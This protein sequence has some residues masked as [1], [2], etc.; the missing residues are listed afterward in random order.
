MNLAILGCG[1]WAQYQIA[2][3]REVGGVTIVGV[4]DRD[5][6]K[7]E[8]TAQR[9]GVPQVFTDA[10]ELL[11]GT[12][13]DCVD[14]ISS[15]E[16]HEAL[17]LL[18]AERGV[19]VICQKPMAPDW[20]ACERMVAACEAAGVPFFIHENF[21][22]QVPIR[23]VKALLDSGEIGRPFRS[24][25]YFNTNFPVFDNQPNL[26]DLE[27]FILADLGVHLLDVQ[28]FLFGEVRSLRCLTQTALPAVRGEDVATILLETVGG[29]HGVVELSF[30]SLVPD[31]A[32]PQTLLRVEGTEG[33]VALG[34]D[35]AL[36]VTTRAGT[37]TETLVL[38][39]YDWV[40]PDYAVAHTSMVPCNQNFYNAL[41]QGTPAETTARDNLE[42]LR[43]V[44]AAYES[45]R[46]GKTIEFGN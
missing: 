22:W 6:D 23:R 21:R 10:T 7:A 1:F 27:Q 2:A 28:R 37:R 16:T 11:E 31:D 45:A 40:N 4:C 3:W 26:R 43:L 8:A 5:R 9:F 19:P 24:R 13:P 25:L 18:A 39:A 17:V 32:F 12:R 15:P 34:K 36:T 29:M 42:T 38:P 33:S 41:T 30:A 46:S 14:I 35:Y 44:Y 20:A